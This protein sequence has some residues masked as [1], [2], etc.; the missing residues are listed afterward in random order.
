MGKLS[1]ILLGTIV[2]LSVNGQENP[3]FQVTSCNADV[4]LK[5]GWDS[6]KKTISIVSD[7][8]FDQFLELKLNKYYSGCYTSHDVQNWARILW[9]QHYWRR[10]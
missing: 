7:E 1:K 8:N 4:S 3:T 9:K 2:C 10:W 5:L 6:G